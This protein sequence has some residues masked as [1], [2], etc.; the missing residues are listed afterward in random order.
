MRMLNSGSRKAGISGLRE[1]TE[2]FHEDYSF[3]LM[4]ETAD[5]LTAAWEGTEPDQETK[6]A[7]IT[8]LTAKYPEAE[9]M[10]RQIVG[11]FH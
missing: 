6:E 10:I 2:L 11:S 7:M 8:E 1:N 5:Y 4:E 3:D 9:E